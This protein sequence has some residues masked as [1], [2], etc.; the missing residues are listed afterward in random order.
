MHRLDVAVQSPRD[1]RGGA[2]DTDAVGQWNAD[3]LCDAVRANDVRNA[4]LCLKH[5]SPNERE[6][7]HF[8]PLRL[9]ALYGRCQILRLLLEAQATVND[10]E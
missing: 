1:E 2:G 9:A 7:T 4:A 3:C 8:S 5:V 10:K 6:T